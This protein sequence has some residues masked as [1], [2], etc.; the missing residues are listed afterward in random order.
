MSA[1]VNSSVLLERVGPPPANTPKVLLPAPPPSLDA[2]PKEAVVAKDVPSYD[3]V[4]TDAEP[5]KIKPAVNV[6]AV[7]N[8]LVLAVFEAFPDVQA[9]PLYSSVNFPGG[10]KP[11]FA[12]LAV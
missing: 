1:S 9:E 5:E 12:T 4:L 11:P 2:V 8:L 6:P 10:G 3:S 7:P